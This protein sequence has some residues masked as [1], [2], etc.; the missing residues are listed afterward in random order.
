MRQGPR[1]FYRVS[2]GDSDIP[3]TCEIKEEPAFKSWQGNLAVVRVRASRCPLTLR[4]QLQGLIH[5]PIAERSFLLRCF[6]KVGIPFV[7]KPDNQ[8]SFREVLGFTELCFSCVL[9][10]VFL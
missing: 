2:T 9:N 5:I 1:A 10:L 4:Q 8:L 6:W 3:I 7:L